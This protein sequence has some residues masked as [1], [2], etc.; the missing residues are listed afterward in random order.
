MPKFWTW[1]LETWTFI[2][3]AAALVQPWLVGLWRRVRTSVDIHET[4]LIEV[5]FSAFGAT[6]GLY[7][8]LR[9]RHRDVFVDKATVEVIKLKHRSRHRFEWAAFRKTK[10]ILG[11]TTG[12]SHETEADIPT[13]FMIS[14]ATPH[15]YNII[16][17]DTLLFQE[18]KP[19]IINFRQTWAN[20]LQQKNLNA[21][22][23]QQRVQL[24]AAAYQEFSRS[25]EYIDAYTAI[26]R[27]FYWEQGTYELTFYV[28]TSRPNR[29][30]K[31]TWLFE[32]SEEDARNLRMNSLKILDEMSGM[33]PIAM[34][35][36]ANVPYIQRDAARNI[37]G[38]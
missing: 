27:A 32:L 34:Y 11:L 19:L 8:T 6:I 15:T 25:Q 3:A 7:G 22:S 28:H 16:F 35:H 4:A 10:T 30:H 21:K 12:E 37:E 1:S 2:V 33:V 13:G 20:L 14:T 17:F 18:L 38:R 9:A 29:V 31:E 5:G 26:D 36:F 23:E 24:V